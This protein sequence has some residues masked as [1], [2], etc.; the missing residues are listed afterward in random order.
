MK[1]TWFSRTFR[2]SHKDLNSMEKKRVEPC[3][4]IILVWEARLSR[5]G[6]GILL[7]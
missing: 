7:I 1:L 3:R 6:M 5:L 4:P 2:G